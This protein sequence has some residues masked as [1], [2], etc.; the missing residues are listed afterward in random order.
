MPGELITRK[1][2]TLITKCSMVVVDLSGNN[3]NVMWELGNAMSKAKNVV[4]IVDKEQAGNL[5]SNLSGLFYLTYSF[6]EDNFEFVDSLER[7]LNE[8]QDKNGYGDGVQNYHRLLEKDEYEA[9]VI[10]AFRYLE[11]LFTD[12][13]AFKVVPVP[14]VFSSLYTENEKFKKLIS[15]T[16]KYRQIRNHIVHGSMN[17]SKEEAIEIVKNIDEVCKAIK[18]GDIIFKIDK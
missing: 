15:D 18:N 4:L 5:P 3:A 13:S 7:Y 16:K 2:D 11:T 12:N 1:V 17:I 6:S 14:N 8:I 9:A 10:M